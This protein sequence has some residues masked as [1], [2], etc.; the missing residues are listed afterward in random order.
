VLSY[1][2]YRDNG[3]IAT[4]DLNRLGVGR[5]DA[6][7]ARIEAEKYFRISGGAVGETPGGGF[8]VRG[9]RDGSYLAYPNVAN[10]RA[11]SRITFRGSSTKGATIQIRAGGIEGK[12][13]GN[14]PF[15]ATGDWASYKE[16][17]CDLKNAAKT[18]DIFLVFKG[19]AGELMRLDWFSFP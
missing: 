9:L 10:L 6:N 11:N 14:C 1:V 5:Y 12:L 16:A 13:L 8:E 3:E 18:T 7:E 2:H 19:D 4:V 15:P 17:G